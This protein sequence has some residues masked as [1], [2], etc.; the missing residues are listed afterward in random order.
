M[1]D[2]RDS[3]TTGL[4]VYNKTEDYEAKV[5]YYFVDSAFMFDGFE[6]KIRLACL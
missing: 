1:Q 4:Q 3:K 6:C 5:Y 2:S